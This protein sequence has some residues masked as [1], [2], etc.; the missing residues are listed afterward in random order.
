MYLLRYFKLH[1]L[2]R[3]ES[4][5][6]GPFGQYYFIE[7]LSSTPSSIVYSIS[8][9]HLRRSMHNTLQFLQWIV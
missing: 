1:T 4:T 3:V 2:S 8:I 5:S 9:L 7:L 6:G